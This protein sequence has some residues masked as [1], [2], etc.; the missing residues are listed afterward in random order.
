MDRIN[1]HK[2]LYT[3]HIITTVGISLSV[4]IDFKESLNLCNEYKCIF[5]NGTLN[6]HIL[7]I[8]YIIPFITSCWII[9]IM[10]T[11][12]ILDSTYNLSFLI[13]ITYF[14]SLIITIMLVT[15]FI[16]SPSVV[17]PYESIPKPNN[18]LIYIKII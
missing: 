14:G 10:R 15:C 3:L 17:I 16:I 12:N 8:V 7:L 18:P 1:E 4:I 13:V 2:I 9:N 6:G 11:E 5:N